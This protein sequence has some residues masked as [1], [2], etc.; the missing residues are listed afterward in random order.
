MAELLRYVFVRIHFGFRGTPHS[1]GS[2]PPIEQRR[3]LIFA[4][5]FSRVAAVAIADAF[6]FRVVEFAEPA[7]RRDGRLEPVAES[8]P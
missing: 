5:P 7:D 8:R 1:P 4:C 3:V 2:D 6:A